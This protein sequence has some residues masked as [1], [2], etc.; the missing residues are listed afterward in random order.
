MANRL[1]IRHGNSAPTLTDLLPYELG[2]DGSILYINN[3]GT[4]T[5]LGGAGAYLPLTGGTLTGDIGVTKTGDPSIFVNN[6]S[7]HKVG[8]IVDNTSA[9]G[10]IWDYTNNKWIVYST[11]AGAVTLNGNATTATSAVSATS[12]TSATQDG[13]GNV[14]ATTYLPLS[15]GKLTDNLNIEKA[16]DTY[17]TAKNTTTSSKVY[18]DAGSGINHGIWSDGY[19]NGSSFVSDGKWIICRTSNGDILSKGCAIIT[20]SSTTARKV[21]LTNTASTPS[22]AVE[23]DLVL[24]KV[25]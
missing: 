21:W 10:G 25:T 8:L 3:N 17:V 7:N 13:N 20:D 5:A 14:I 6:N 22:G 19:Y 11:T 23:G 1:K 2:W 24:V 12:A 15:G 16:G 18:L 4:I 9:N